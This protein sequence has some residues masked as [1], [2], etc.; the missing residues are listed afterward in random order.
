MV[1]SRGESLTLHISQ[2]KLLNAIAAAAVISA[3][4]NSAAPAEAFWEHITRRYSSKS[5][6]EEA[7]RDFGIFNG[8]IKVIE[9]SRVKKLDNGFCKDDPST[10]QILGYQYMDISKINT[11]RNYPPSVTYHPK[12]KWRYYY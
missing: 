7:C 3:S 9:G 12:V 10:R 4:F 2:M 6:A 11:S 8:S 1:C 5:E